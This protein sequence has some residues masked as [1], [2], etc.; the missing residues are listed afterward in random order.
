V[1]GFLIIAGVAAVTKGEGVMYGVVAAILLP[2]VTA[3][4]LRRKVRY[5]RNS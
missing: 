4:N 2:I 1:L 5:V 3:I